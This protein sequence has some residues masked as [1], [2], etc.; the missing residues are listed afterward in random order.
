[1]LPWIAA[2]FAA[3]IAFGDRGAVAVGAF[4]VGLVQALVL[5]IAIRDARGRAACAAAAVLAAGALTMTERREAALWTLAVSRV[6]ATV[7]A[8]VDARR[9]RGDAIAIDLASLRRVDGDRAA[10]PHRVRIHV[11]A[12]VPSDLATAVPGD[13]VRARIRVRPVVS[14]FDPG[15]GDPA[16]TLRRRGIAATGGLVHPSLVWR[17]ERSAARALVARARERRSAAAA[18]LAAR[19]ASLAGALALGARQALPAADAEAIRSAGLTHLL[20]V[21]GLNLAMVAALVFGMARRI[22]LRLA[23]R[24]VVD[25]RRA[26]LAAAWGASVAYAALTGFDVSVRRALAFLTIACAAL[27]LRRPVAPASVVALGAIAILAADPPAL[28]DPGAQL[29]FAAASALLVAARPPAATAAT[30]SERARA[31]L[32]GAVET[33]AVALAATAPIVAFHFGRLAPGALAANL[34]AVPLTEIVL[35]PLSLLAALLALAAPDATWL[36]AA[37]AALVR[38]GAS[39]LVA[40]ARAASSGPAAELAVGAAPLA[41]GLATLAGAAAVAVRGTSARVALV[42]A[43]HGALVLIPPRAYVPAPP[44]M[45]SLDVGQGDAVLVQGLRGALLVD[46]GPAMPG[47]ADLGRAVV[48]PALAALG[49]RKLDVVAASHADLDHRG[50]LGAVIERVPVVELWLPFGGARDAGFA[51][52]VALAR[53]R[54]V[55][56]RERGAGDA[57]QAVG[58]LAVEPLWPPPGAEGAGLRDNDRSLVL[59][60]TVASTRVLLTGD[61]ERGAESALLASADVAADVLKLGHHGSRTSSTAAFVRAVG[62]ELAIASAPCLGRFRMPHPDVAERL[63]R[64]RTSLW[65]TGRDGA[66]FVGLARPRVAV[67]LAPARDPGE[68]WTCAP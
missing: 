26:A 2:S 21:S 31:W 34:V 66:L 20:A 30:R 33:S 14:R 57:T 65:W 7:E 52:L 22:C 1:V 67:G 24:R 51:A 36:F 39:A 12:R 48:V 56:V 45:V 37:P 43:A 8:T 17:F 41:L 5:G 49:V 23:P 11:D 19:G 62:A 16:E 46:A 53:E 61:L 47:G 63:S 3:G 35:L 10:F 44:R 32:R 42:A 25:P 6:E 28:F 4:Q 68:R 60:V 59:R 38:V 64:A 29:S 15:S 18:A 40:I 27:W 55:R 13:V 50:G 54:G 58:D 9:E